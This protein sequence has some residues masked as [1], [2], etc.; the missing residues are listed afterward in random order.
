M[1]EENQNAQLDDFFS[2]TKKIMEKYKHLKHSYSNI[3][4]VEQSAFFCDLI[5]LS[6]TYS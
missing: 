6:K 3:K 5:D 1:K 2:K 4:A